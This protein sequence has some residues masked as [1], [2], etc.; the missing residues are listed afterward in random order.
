VLAETLALAHPV[1][2]FVTEELWSHVP[3]ADGLLMARRWPVADERRLDPAAEEELARAIAAVQGLRGWRDRV[4]AA[5]AAVLPARLEAEGY[6]RTAAH[7]ARLARC[8][9][10]ADGAEPAATVPVPGGAVAVLASEAVDLEAAG[11]RL[12]QRRGLVLGEIERAERKLG[13]DGVVAKAPAP[14]VQAERDKLARLREELAA[15]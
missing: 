1:I 3:G 13:N 4:G 11:R 15:L 2:P 6:E 10:S 12:E 5:P 9:W 8:A 7:V 14:V